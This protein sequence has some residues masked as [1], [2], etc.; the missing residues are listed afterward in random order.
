M[1]MVLTSSN[2]LDEHIRLCLAI[3]ILTY[4]SPIPTLLN[5]HK[6]KGA[7]PLHRHAFRL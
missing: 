2:R 3:K 6:A 4:K 7:F 5:T 1:I